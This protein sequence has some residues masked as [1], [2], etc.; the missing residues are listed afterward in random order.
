MNSI[1]RA[2]DLLVGLSLGEGEMGVSGLSPTQETRALGNQTA[3]HASVASFKEGK[4]DL[5]TAHLFP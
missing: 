1:R 3:V 4:K 2:G 5:P